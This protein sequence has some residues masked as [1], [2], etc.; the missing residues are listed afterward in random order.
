MKKK[1][2]LA[3]A[4]VAGISS[5]ALYAKPPVSECEVNCTDFCRYAGLC[6]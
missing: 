3:L 6:G 5:G 4:I 1:L 2:I